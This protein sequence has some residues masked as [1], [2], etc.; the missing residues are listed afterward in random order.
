MNKIYRLSFFVINILAI[1]SAGCAPATVASTN[2]TPP[3]VS[4]ASAPALPTTIATPSIVTLDPCS[5]VVEAKV[6][7]SQILEVVLEYEV[8]SFPQIISEFGSPGGT[9]F[10]NLA[11]W[12]EATNRAFPLPLPP[13]ALNP[14][15]S[16]DHRWV[17]FRRDISETQSEFWVIGTNGN[18]EK[19]LGAV[20]LGEEL[21][22]RYPDGMFSLDYGWI[23][24]SD[25]FYY[26]VDVTYGPIP[27]L[28]FDKFV[29]VDANTGQAI[30]LENSTQINEFYFSPDGTQM[31]VGTEGE[32]YALRTDDGIRQFTVQALLSYFM[33]SPDG[34][35]IVDFTDDGIFQINAQTGRQLAIPLKYTTLRLNEPTGFERPREF[36][37]ISASTFLFVSLNSD[38]RV[39]SLLPYIGNPDPEWTFTVWQVDLEDG[40]AHPIQVFRGDPSTVRFSPDAKLLAFQKFEVSGESKRRDMYLADIASSEILETIPG[41]LFHEWLPDS[42]RYLYQTGISYSPPGKGDPTT[43]PGESIPVNQYLGQVDGIPI[44]MNWENVSWYDW[45]WVDENRLVTDCKIVKFP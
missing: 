19:K 43:V 26:T 11:L 16:P 39:V 17:L 14:I 45:W 5:C 44:L 1:L 13:D 7:N 31:A 35:Y 24:N 38:E 4:T 25:K 22:I 33:Y 29:L 3:P 41:G 18:N 10:V 23:P 37:W 6:F 27:P 30:Q 34:T 9:R 21:K 28:I 42:E 32:F 36:A 8:A 12:S 20:S 40:T 2:T 15:I